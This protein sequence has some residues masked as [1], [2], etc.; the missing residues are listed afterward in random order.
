[1]LSDSFYT[2][3]PPGL[4]LTLITLLLATFRLRYWTLVIGGL[5]V[6]LMTGPFLFLTTVLVGQ[7]FYFEGD[8][9][10]AFFTWFVLAICP[11]TLS[12]VA[13]RQ[14]YKREHPFQE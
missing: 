7:L 4:V 6:A 2:L 1:M 12:F 11:L 10:R 5:S 14:A 9:A 3:L 13:T 8:T